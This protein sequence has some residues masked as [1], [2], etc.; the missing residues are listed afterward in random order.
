MPK[1]ISEEEIRAVVEEQRPEIYYIPEGRLLSPAARDY[2]NELVIPFDNESNREQNEMRKKREEQMELDKQEKTHVV[3]DADDAAPRRI[4]AKFVDYRTGTPYGSKPEAMTHIKGNKLVFK[5]DPIIV[6]RGKLDHAQAIIVDV[7]AR[8]YENNGCEQLIA[9]LEEILGDLRQ[10]M[11]C[12]VRQQPCEIDTVL[13]LSH[14]ELRAQSHDPQKYFGVKP[15]TLPEYT[16]GATYAGLNL[17]RTEIRQVE[18]AAVAAFRNGRNVERT[19]IIEV[20][21]RL[22]SAMHIIMCRYLQ[23]GIYK[24]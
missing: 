10:L 21:N 11:S 6:Y 14:D 19:D 2:L 1:L 5:D 22:S 15:M 23:G 16:M 13:G 18:L 9:D 7:Q 4:G 12:E 20:L 8:I 17:I 24:K 3:T